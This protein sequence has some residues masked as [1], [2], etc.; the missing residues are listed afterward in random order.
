MMLIWFRFSQIKSASLTRDKLSL[1][2]PPKEVFA[3]NRTDKKHGLATSKN[4]SSV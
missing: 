2:G 1:Q 3:E 4:Y